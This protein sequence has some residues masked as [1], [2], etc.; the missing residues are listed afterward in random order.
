MEL[1]LPS[2]TT[3]L[4]TGHGTGYPLPG[5][6]DEIEQNLT[7]VDPT[8]KR[9]GGMDS[10]GFLQKITRFAWYKSWFRTWFLF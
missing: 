10:G 7:K 6:Y 4:R 8:L 1:S 5:G 3:T 9:Y 2:H